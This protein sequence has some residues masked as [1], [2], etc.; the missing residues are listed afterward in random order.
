MSELDR[1]DV[2]VRAAGRVNYRLTYAATPIP[3]E[4][5]SGS[6]FGP[7]IPNAYDPDG[8]SLGSG[9]WCDP[10]FWSAV[11]DAPTERDVIDRW[12]VTAVREAIHESLEWFRVDGRIYLDPHGDHEREIHILSEELGKALV[13]LAKSKESA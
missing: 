9:E 12:F 10:E 7:D 4:M 2:V 8:S 6:I 3:R 13:S 5:D 1:E 11:G